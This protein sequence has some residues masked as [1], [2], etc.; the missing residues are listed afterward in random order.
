M[1]RAS[2][3]RARGRAAPRRRPSVG[4][5]VPRLEGR[6]KL[7]GAARYVADLDVDGALWG[8]TVRSPHAHAR[9]LS[10][11][12]DPS[13]D[14]DSV[15]LVTA[16]DLAR[17]GLANV[18]AL[19]E[20]DQP[21]LADGVTRHPEEAVA[22]VAAPTR[23]AAEAAAAALRID[24]EALAP[25]LDYRRSKRAY[26]RLRI[27]RGD[28][29]SARAGAALVVE[30]TYEF[31][32]QEHAYIE[33][34]GVVALPGE[35]GSMRV[36]GSMQCPYYVHKALVRLLGIDGGRVS[37]AQATTGGGFGG[38]EEYP[39][40]IAGHAAILARA[41]GRPVR[42]LYDRAED[43][44]ATTK[45]HP[46]HVRHRTAVDRDGRLVGMEIEIV[47]D[48]GA[49]A[50]LSPVVLSRATIHAAGPYRCPN[51]RIE[52]RVTAT[53]APPHGAFRGFGVPQVAFALERQMDRVARRLGI[54]PV[55]LRRRNLLADGE[56]IATGQKVS[57]AGDGRAALDAALARSRWES[58]RASFAA[59]NRRQ[60]RKRRGLGLATYFHGTGFTGGGE[61]HLASVAGVELRP[62]GRVRVLSASTEIGQG[63]RTVFAQIVAD[64]IAIPLERVELEEPDTAL[65]PDSG[66][67]VAS[68]T[69]TIVGR[70]VADAARDLDRSLREE[71]GAG[72]EP[73]T[74][75]AFERAAA[76][77]LAN[78]G[79]TRFLARFS[80]PAGQVWDEKSY[81][82]DAYGAYAWA[83]TVA[84]VEV[85][86]A[87]C[88]VRVLGVT[89]AQQ[90]GRAIHP[91]LA[92]GQIEGGLAQALGYGLFE[93]VQ[94]RDGRMA[95][96]QLTNYI[97]PTAVDT[98]PIDLVL[99]ERPYPHGPFGAKGVGELPMDGGAPAAVNAICDALGVELD[100]IP[101]TPERILA[102][103]EGASR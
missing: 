66:P 12:P 70:I 33:N 38:K 46:G 19:I 10:I 78:G 20:E 26:D 75:R 43:M 93:E 47:L 76:R 97:L 14:W 101:A 100:A 86:L 9:I 90:F 77:R 98:P 99:L 74:P 52:G 34:N 16:A 91:R 29:A 24:Y 54:D 4:T 55:E 50:T 2:A 88:E 25:E 64:T 36:V 13:F 61:V 83:A 51:V 37:V 103:L 23:E 56:A 94:W 6:D 59:F 87:T 40:L 1:A 45:R 15:T 32:A 17:L 80:N 68:R 85:D 21:F 102:A 92:E 18:V 82:G 27:A 3:A 81:T 53:N 49:Y 44:A 5:N 39:N 73:W 71:S 48:G 84:A 8:L 65:V 95:N 42:I 57:D 7:T 35:D 11:T 69:V 67:T 63:T 96:G 31:G 62:G 89:S 28:A 30:A 58:R 60:K 72:E 22:L 41:A 79:P